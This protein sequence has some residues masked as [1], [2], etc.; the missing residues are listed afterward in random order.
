MRAIGLLG[1]MSWES[2]AVYYRLINTMVRERLGGL[3][4]VHIVVQS[5]DFARVIDRQMAGD[6]DG[7]GAMLAEAAGRLVEG[8]ADS[9]LICTNTMH[10]VAQPVIARMA[11]VR[12]NATFI[13]IMDETAPVLHA[14]RRKRPL[15]LATRYTMEHGFYADHMRGHGIDVVMP[16]AE[17]RAT[18]H[19]II[20]EELCQGIVRD[21]SREKMMRI[22][23]RGMAAGADAAI[24]GCTEICLLLDP[25]KLPCPGFDTTTIHAR[26]AVEFALADVMST[27]AAA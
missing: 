24:L 16:D 1:G 15:L 11:A 19:S 22:I 10:I 18:V 20:F 12:P 27:A 5:L 23:E 14:A 4:S 6:W 2:T 25:D 21:S 7:A 13:N 17:D 8:G 26:S 9:V 3:N